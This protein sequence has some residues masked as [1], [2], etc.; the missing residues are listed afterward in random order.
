MVPP[1][2]SQSWDFSNLGK[3]E[4]V[5]A[6][7][8]HSLE[9]FSYQ[10]TGTGMSRV[11]IVWWTLGDVFPSHP[12]QALGGTCSPPSFPGVVRLRV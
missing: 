2:L 9:A 10:E 5:Y 6:L 3:D 4:R 1:C 8:P 7:T 11:L 12:S